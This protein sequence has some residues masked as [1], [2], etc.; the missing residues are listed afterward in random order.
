MQGEQVEKDGVC[1]MF[2]FIMMHHKQE[3]DANN[4]LFQ[5]SLI[6]KECLL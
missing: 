2:F 1:L 4:I 5:E 3:L 6:C